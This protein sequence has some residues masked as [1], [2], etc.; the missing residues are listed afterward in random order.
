MCIL[1]PHTGRSTRLGY[2]KRSRPVISIPTFIQVLV[3]PADEHNFTRRGNSSLG[4]RGPDNTVVVC[5]DDIT[6]F[7]SS[8]LYGKMLESVWIRRSVWSRDYIIVP[9]WKHYSVVF[10]SDDATAE[11]VWSILVFDRMPLLTIYENIT[12]TVEAEKKLTMTFDSL[13]RISL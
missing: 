3:S 5:C 13:Y 4:H 8:T 1:S 10:L 12:F 9:L 11:T 6:W 7:Y 2:F